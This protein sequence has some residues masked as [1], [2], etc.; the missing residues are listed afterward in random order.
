MGKRLDMCMDYVVLF[1]RMHIDFITA[2]KSIL[3]EVKSWE[4]SLPYNIL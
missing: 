4:T 2:N 3:S 1:T